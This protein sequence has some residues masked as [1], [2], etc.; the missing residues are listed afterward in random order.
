MQVKTV[1][2]GTQSLVV[3]VL[4]LGCTGMMGSIKATTHGEADGQV[5][6]REKM[7]AR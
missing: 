3:P 6:W 4:G 5:W 2:L 7:Q 1:S